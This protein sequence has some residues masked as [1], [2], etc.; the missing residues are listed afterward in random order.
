M[1]KQTDEAD[2]L[3]RAG[4][5]DTG[6][7]GA[8][9]ERYLDTIYRYVYY[10]TGDV[11]DAEDLTETVFLKAWQAMGGYRI[12]G[13]PFRA[14]LFRIAHNSVVD[15]Y[16]RRRLVEPLERHEQVGDGRSHLDDQVAANEQQRRLVTAV[17]QLSP[18]HQH[19][20]VLRFVEELSHDEVAAVLNR[21]AAAVRV[22]QHRA[23]KELH[24]L[25]ALEEAKHA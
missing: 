20:V 24:A 1:V 14:W 18:L 8:L 4:R 9:Y 3:R 15:H 19:V 5:G 25:L 22:L 12:T 16:R 2:L 23:L 6:A 17:K 21:T 7:F 13:V 11:Q 10:R